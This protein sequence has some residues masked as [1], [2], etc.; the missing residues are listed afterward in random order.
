MLDMGRRC[1]NPGEEDSCMQSVVDIREETADYACNE[2]AAEVL[3]I[4]RCRSRDIFTY[5]LHI[6]NAK[7][8]SVANLSDGDVVLDIHG[9]GTG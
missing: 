5:F 8:N 2:S 4:S 9:R 3:L 6:S 1:T 7:L